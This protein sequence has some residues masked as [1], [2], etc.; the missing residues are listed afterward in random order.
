MKPEKSLFPN[1]PLVI[2]LL[3]PTA[4]GKT[5][6]AVKLAERLKL[7]IHNVDSRQL[8]IG[9]DIGTA[10]PTKAQQDRVQHYLIDLRRPNEPITVQEFQKTANFFLEQSLQSHRAALV[11]GG[12]GLYLKAITSGLKPPPV[13]PQ[14]FLRKQLKTIGQDMCYRMLQVS[15]PIAAQRISSK[16][17]VRTTRALEVLYATTHSITRL[18]TVEPPP[19]QIL[20]IGL[21]PKNLRER[22][23]YRTKMI[24]ENG[25]LEET[26]EL[27][28]RYGDDL[29]MLQTIGYKEALDVLKR[30]SNLSEAIIKTTQRTNQ[31]AKK[32]R[33]WFRKQHNPQWLNDKDPFREALSLIKSGLV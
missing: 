16:D 17:A 19:W 4:G 32:Q 26:K 1:K 9:M 8:Y 13:A 11:V 14:P 10:K 30:Q 24:Y 23:A 7:H 6:L 31:F 15:D 21:D 33:T 5:A 3:G 12:S 28:N 27:S 2:V 20:E 29:P 25:L 22:I 18:E